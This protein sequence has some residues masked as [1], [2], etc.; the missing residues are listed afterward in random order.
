VGI[1]LCQ[2]LR[3]DE[4]ETRLGN[5]EDLCYYSSDTSVRICPWLKVVFKPSPFGSPYGTS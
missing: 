2:G 5:S 3:S 1:R 4:S